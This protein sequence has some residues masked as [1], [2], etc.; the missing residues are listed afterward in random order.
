MKERGEWDKYGRP[1][2]IDFGKFSREYSKVMDGKL[3][4]LTKKEFFKL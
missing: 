2:A 3:R 4:N 1:K